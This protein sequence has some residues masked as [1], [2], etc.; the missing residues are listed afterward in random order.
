MSYEQAIYNK[1]RESAERAYE[2]IPKVNDS[3]ARKL[4]A[5]PEVAITYI[6]NQILPLV[7]QEYPEDKFTEAHGQ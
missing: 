6:T 4:P 7:R 1:A 2:V 3:Y 5:D